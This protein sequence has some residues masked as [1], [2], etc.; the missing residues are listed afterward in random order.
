MSEG[1]EAQPFD[2]LVNGEGL[3]VVLE[4]QRYP[5]SIGSVLS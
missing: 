2:K 1:I 5:Q 4:K 3:D